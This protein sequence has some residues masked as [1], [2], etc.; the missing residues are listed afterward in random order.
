MSK[1]TFDQTRCEKCK[2]CLSFKYRNK[3]EKIADVT[4]RWCY[5]DRLRHRTNDI[6][7]AILDIMEIARQA[8]SAQ[9]RRVLER[10]DDEE[11]EEEVQDCNK[12]AKQSLAEIKSRIRTLERKAAKEVAP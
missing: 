11:F 9:A 3:G 12:L 2:T 10:K 7:R 8:I 4:C 5:L 1:I 6:E